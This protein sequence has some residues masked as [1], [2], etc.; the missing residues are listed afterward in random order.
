M[1]TN[2]TPE[3]GRDARFT[4]SLLADVFRVL[5]AHGYRHPLDGTTAHHVAIARS[6]VA[7]GQ[8]AEAFEGGDQ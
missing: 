5:E 8:L 1:N 4:L 6:M 3:Q 7:L 2:T